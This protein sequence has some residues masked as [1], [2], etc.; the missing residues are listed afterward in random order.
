MKEARSP[1]PELSSFQTV[2]L[3]P[4][5]ARHARFPWTTALYLERL[6]VISLKVRESDS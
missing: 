3:L 2:T 4:M 6:K 5:F 1:F